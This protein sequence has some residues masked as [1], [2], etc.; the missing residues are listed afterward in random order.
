MKARVRTATLGIALL[1]GVS[2]LGG[3]SMRPQIAVAAARSQTGVRYVYGGASRSEGFD[4]SG[5]TS[6]A[7]K[8]AGVSIP[9]TSRDQYYAT[10]RISRAQLQPGDLVF[11]GYSGRVSHVA[12]YVGGGRIIQA[13][14]TGTTVQEDYV[15][16]YWTSA[17]IGYGRVRM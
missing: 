7:W 13:R 6:W 3:C 12:M 4:C 10:A 5:L 15:D 17:L 1:V 16:R 9:R 8:Q 2:S 11:Y 14:K